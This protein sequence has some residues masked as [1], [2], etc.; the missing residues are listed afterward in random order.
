[1][2]KLSTEIEQAARALGQA[3]RA[4]PSTQAYL[5][6]AQR[7]EANPDVCNLEKT[8]YATYDALIARQQAGESIPQSE[9]QA[10]Y[11]LRDRFFGHPLVQEREQALHDLKELFQETVARLTAS[12]GVDYTQLAQ[13]EE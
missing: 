6:A 5:E 1:M 13:K 10:F 2:T 4:Q 12:L 8:L 3:L 9:I 11:E 7:L